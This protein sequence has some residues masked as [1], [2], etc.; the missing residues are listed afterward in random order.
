MTRDEQFK[1]AIADADTKFREAVE[2]AP[3][4]SKGLAAWAI[5]AIIVCVHAYDVFVLHR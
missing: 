5:I 2:S 3:W 1:N 4:W